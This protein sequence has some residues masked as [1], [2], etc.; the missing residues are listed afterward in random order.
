MSRKVLRVGIYF[1]LSMQRKIIHVDMDAFYASIEQRDNPRLRGKPIAVGN[2][3]LR[4]VVAAASYEARQFGVHSAMSSVK[5]KKLCPQLIFV[6]GRMNVYKEVSRQI[7]KIFHRYTYLV[8]SLSLDEAFLD[9]TE[10]KYGIELAVDVAKRIKY[11]IRQELSLT[12]SA[13]VSYNK[14]LAKIASDYR[15]P[16]GLFTIHP[17]KA[18]EFIATLPVEAFWGV[19]RATAERMHRLG[20]RVGADLREKDLAYLLQHFGKVGYVFYCFSRGVDERPVEP[21]RIRKTVGCEETYER[22]LTVQEAHDVYLPELVT[23]LMRRLKRTGF[24]GNCL[25]LKIKFPD[26]VQ[27]TRSLTLPENFQTEAQFLATARVLLEQFEQSSKNI[28]L[29]GLSLSKSREEPPETWEQLLLNFENA[30]C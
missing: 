14:F 1:T 20:I 15:K 7:H 5:A 10:N 22:D 6:P 8:E 27:K 26:F 4:G 19:G 23:E 2:A 12:A 11:D 16:D 21:F 9:V 28:R 17:S 3:E 30:T 25:T 24:Q 13:G 18:E 29:M